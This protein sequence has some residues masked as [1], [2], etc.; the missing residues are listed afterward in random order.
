MLWSCGKK[1]EAAPAEGTAT[2]PAEEATPTAPPAEEPALAAGTRG[3]GMMG[4]MAAS[5]PMAIEDAKVEVADTDKG[6]A[7]TF[8]TEKGD[9]ADL[10]ARVQQM[11]TMYQQ[12]GGRR[13][14]MWHQGRG[15]GMGAG[16]G[17]GPGAGRGMGPGAG[18][19]PMPALTATVTE[20]DKGARVE[21]VP[22]DAA[23]L[24]A[25]R[26]HARFHQQRMSSGECWMMQEE[27]TDTGATT[28]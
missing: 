6:V 16:P 10:R 22:T 2:A 4:Q 25:L 23:Q 13:G 5:C 11:A 26:E 24:D 3:G 28:P 27:G 7:L 12:H 1:E 18:K 20:V 9:V 17:P 19:G 15:A 21:L 14:M 8:T